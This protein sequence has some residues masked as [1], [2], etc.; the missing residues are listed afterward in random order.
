MRQM[1]FLLLLGIVIALGTTTLARAQ[2]DL[3]RY[4]TQEPDPK[5]D[6]AKDKKQKQAKVKNTVN[7]H[8]KHW[9]SLPRFRHKKQESA[10]D[11]RPSAPNSS[12]KTA[13]LKP[14]NAT[15][16]AKPANRGAMTKGQANNT[17]ATKSGQTQ[18]KTVQGAKTGTSGKKTAVTTAH[19]THNAANRSSSSKKTVASASQGKKPVRHDCSDE[20]AKKGACGKTSN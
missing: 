1:K 14:V 19:H 3:E 16:A 10:H 4:K 17:A 18:A 2:E 8:R 15:T 13:A 12:T 7:G 20:D 11:A 6:T 9:Y 5:Q